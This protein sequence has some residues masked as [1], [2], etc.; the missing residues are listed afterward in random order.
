MEW[1]KL[2]VTVTYFMFL[3]YG[4]KYEDLFLHCSVIYRL[5]SNIAVLSID[6]IL[7][8]W[9]YIMVLFFQCDVI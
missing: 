3:Y 8:L 6:F 7:T 1:G 5:G 2:S 9:C 4:V